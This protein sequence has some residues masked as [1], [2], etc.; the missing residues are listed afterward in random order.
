MA[1]GRASQ[2]ICFEGPGTRTVTRATSH[3][4]RGLPQGLPW[5]RQLTL[6]S[7]TGR[8]ETF[9]AFRL[10]GVALPSFCNVRST[11][12]TPRGARHLRAARKNSSKSSSSTRYL[13]LSSGT[14]A[15]ST[16]LRRR[17]LRRSPSNQCPSGTSPLPSSR[18]RTMAGADRSSPYTSTPHLAHRRANGPDPQASSATDR[19]RFPVKDVATLR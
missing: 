15:R 5:L 19:G 13:K 9:Q 4:R 12:K 2:K 1:C 8:R 7:P 10:G 14:T 3:W 6:R 16:R 18:A 11:A 17:K